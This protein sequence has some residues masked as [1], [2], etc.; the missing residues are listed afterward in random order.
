MY[1]YAHLVL[2]LRQQPELARGERQAGQ[3]VLL[4][5]EVLWVH[6][7]ETPSAVLPRG[8]GEGGGCSPLFLLGTLR[9]GLQVKLQHVPPILVSAEVP[10]HGGNNR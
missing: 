7:E 9:Q 1:T 2:G 6:R 8:L 10:L 4:A 5:Q 3:V